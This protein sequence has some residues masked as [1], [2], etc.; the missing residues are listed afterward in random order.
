MGA[1]T[2]CSCPSMILLDLL[3]TE[4]Y[5]FGTHITDPNLDLFSFVK[6]SRYA[7]ELVSDGDGGLE[8]RFSCNVCLQGSM[9]AYKLINELSGVMRSFPI[10]MNG[11]AVSYTHLTLP[12]PPY[13]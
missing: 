7:N 13:V 6:A 11:N 9:D 3:T 2:W 1:A 8:A 4:R 12:T 5:G 10:W